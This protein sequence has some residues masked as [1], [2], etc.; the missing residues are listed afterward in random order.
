MLLISIQ[1][2][3]DSTICS[4]PFSAV[5]FF[6][7]SPWL[8]IPEHRKAEITIKPRYPRLGL[9]G[10]AS[11]GN[12]M[13]K[14]AALAAKRKQQTS[15][16]PGSGSNATLARADDYTAS[17]DRLRISKPAETLLG[18]G[19][20]E[21]QKQMTQEDLPMKGA[22]D[23]PRSHGKQNDASKDQLDQLILVDPNIRGRPSAFASIMISQATEKESQ[24]SSDVFSKRLLPKTFDFTEPSP[25]DIVT[26]AQN[27]KGRS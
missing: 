23:D 27:A 26:R 11:K 17:L 12:K 20:G 6:K 22:G 8:Q 3:A 2:I 9:L 7:D 19:D 13:S 21:T 18:Q 1:E 25:D 14:L 16:Q 4:T 24:P 10:G 5:E 15:E